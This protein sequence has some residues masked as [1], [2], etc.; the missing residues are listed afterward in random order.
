M[1]VLRALSLLAV[2]FVPALLAAGDV[3]RG[4]DRTAPLQAQ[5]R[6]V[7]VSALDANGAPVTDLTATDFIVKEGGKPR[8]V[9][10][11]APATAPMHI[12]ILIDDN[13]TGLFRYSV[14]KFIERLQGRAVFAVSTVTGQ[15]R[16]LVSYTASVEALS[17]ALDG[18]RVRPGSPDGGQLLEGI[19]EAAKDLERRKA[20][21]PV[22]V[23]LTVGGEEHSTV[24]ARLVLDQLRKSGAALHVVSVS[25][26]ALRS[27]VAATSPSA[28]LG[29]NLNL[30]QV[31]GDGS[32]QSGGHRDEIVAAPGI[33]MDLRLLAESLLHQYV[34]EYTLPDGVKPSDKLSVSVTRRGVTL[35]AP[36]RIPL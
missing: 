22:I 7:Y 32:K 2:A 28:L 35:R 18:L 9:T 26:A 23:A 19:F 25:S 29:E 4:D 12:A 24:A 31:L 10:R 30:S 6:T 20:A 17:E 1:T 33:V 3:N 36:T 27:T 5:V 13:G 16:Q 8:D 14:G 21:R 15:V 11:A 34:L